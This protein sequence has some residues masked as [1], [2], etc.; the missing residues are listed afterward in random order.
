MGQAEWWV[1]PDSGELWS[2][3][4]YSSL[5]KKMAPYAEAARAHIPFSCAIVF[6]EACV[7]A[8]RTNTASDI[9]GQP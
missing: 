4:S 6:F 2:G 3:T 7:L 1:G 5:P 9:P 8:S